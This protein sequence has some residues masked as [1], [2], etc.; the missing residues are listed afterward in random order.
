MGFFSRLVPGAKL[1]GRRESAKQG[2]SGEVNWP[3][4]AQCCRIVDA[5]GVENETD[6][7]LEHVKPLGKFFDRTLV[8]PDNPG[9]MSPCFI[10]DGGRW[11]MFFNIGA[12][13]RN[14]IALAIAEPL[15]APADK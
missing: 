2:Q 13:L 9:A 5:Y 1:L 12:R 4:C 6:A 7:A 11:C 14:K 10:E 3:R 8:S 15:T